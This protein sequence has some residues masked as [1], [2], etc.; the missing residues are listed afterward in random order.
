[1]FAAA[2]AVAAAGGNVAVYPAA[3]V[4]H[5]PASTQY[6]TQDEWGQYAYGYS[7]GPSAKHEQRTADGVTRGGYSYVDANGLV[8]SV[9]YVSDPANGFRATGTNFPT[10]TVAAAPVPVVHD[11]PAHPWPAAVVAEPWPAV[12]DARHLALRH[13]PIVT[14]APLVHHPLLKL[15][16]PLTPAGTANLHYPEHAAVVVAGRKKRSAPYPYPLLQ[17]APAAHV[18][19]VKHVEPHLSSV[20]VAYVVPAASSY[21]SVVR[22]S[23]PALAYAAPGPVIV[24]PVHAPVHVPAHGVY[25]SDSRYHAQDEHGQYTYGYTDGASAKTETR[26][27]DGLTKGSYS[28]VD[29]NGAVQAV[30]YT[31]GPDGFRAVGTNIPVH[32]V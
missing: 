27:A 23:P 25:T 2:A 19:T 16:R 21:T 8:Q 14:A 24:G 28:Y 30:H 17:A 7:G 18:V 12:V 13:Q 5:A 4:H 32:H 22:H 31:A 3:V 20:P 10:D 6:H 15:A 1:M 29:D 9:S 26:Y 11:V